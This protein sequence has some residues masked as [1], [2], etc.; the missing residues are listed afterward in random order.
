MSAEKAL[1]SPD[2]LLASLLSENELTGLAL[3]T[4]PSG[5][6]KTSLCER[7]AERARKAGLSVGGILCPPVFEAGSKVGIDQLDLAT[8]ERKRLGVRCDGAGTIG[9]WHLDE[10]VIAWG[11]RIISNLKGEDFIIIDELGPLE[12]ESGDGYQQALRLLDEGRYRKAIVV[13]RPSLLPLA[14]LRWPQAETF[15]LR[16]V[17]Q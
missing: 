4:G 10:R 2:S 6:G 14:Q 9:C 11:N 13:V 3:I 8:G 16:P 1:D 5:C 17:A 12:L 7:L 15:T